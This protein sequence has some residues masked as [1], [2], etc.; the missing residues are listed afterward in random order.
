MEQE[1]KDGFSL[2]VQAVGDFQQMSV[3]DDPESEDV[4]KASQ[5]TSIADGEEDREATLKTLVPVE[6]ISER[7]V[8]SVRNQLTAFAEKESLVIAVEGEM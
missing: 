8:C 2:P 7:D 4:S 1:T 3:E 5:P 6:R